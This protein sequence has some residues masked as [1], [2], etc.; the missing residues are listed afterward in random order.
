MTTCDPSP[1]KNGGTCNISNNKVVC[2][3]TSD[4]TGDTCET[5]IPIPN[6]DPSPCKNGGT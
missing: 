5:E 1:C 4:W 2:S 6:C 3:C